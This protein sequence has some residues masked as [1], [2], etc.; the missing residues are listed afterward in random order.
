MNWKE[1]VDEEINRQKELAGRLSP[2]ELRVRANRSYKEEKRAEAIRLLDEL[3]VAQLLTSLRDEVWKDGTLEGPDDYSIEKYSSSAGATK[4]KDF[5]VYS[6]SFSYVLMKRV[7]SPDY[8]REWQRPNSRDYYSGRHLLTKL[9]VGTGASGGS[10]IYVFS[11]YK[12]GWQKWSGENNGCGFASWDDSFNISGLLDAGQRK[13]ELEKALI[14]ETAA[15]IQAHGLPADFKLT[16]EESIRE[17]EEY[18]RK[19]K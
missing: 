4:K 18:C 6:L 15:R 10:G 12:S 9:S 2:E 7:T 17:A 1:Q 8:S 5:L 11:D 16:S 19:E 3:G 14:G 13:L